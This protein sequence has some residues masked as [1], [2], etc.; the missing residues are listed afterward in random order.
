MRVR[1]RQR[2]LELPETFQWVHETTP[3]L[4]ARDDPAGDLGAAVDP[5]RSRPAADAAGVGCWALTIACSRWRSRSSR[6][7]SAR[8]VRRPAPAGY[9]SATPRTSRRRPWRSCASGCG[10]A[11]TRHGDR[12]GRRRRRWRSGRC[13]RSAT[14]RRSSPSPRFPRRAAAG[15]RAAITSALIAHA[16]SRGVETVFLSAADD[17]VARVYERLGFRRAAHGLLRAVRERPALAGVLGAIVIVVLGDPRRPRRRRAGHRRAVAQ[18][19]RAADRSACSRG[20]SAAAARRRERR[21]AAIAG[22]IFAVDL[23]L[24]H[25][26]IDD[27]GA[28]LATVLGNLQVVDRA[29]RRARCCSASRSRGRSCSRCRRSCLGVLLVSGALEDG[30]YGANPARG[31]LFGDRQRLRLR[32]VHPGPAPRADG[33]R[34]PGRALFDMSVVASVVALIAGPRARRRRPRCRPGR[35]RAG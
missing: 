24:W 13:A 15:S 31:A 8:R 30:A 6:S 29:V 9:A 2:E 33:P 23:T 28:G 11:S 10:P 26:A 1:A 25:D 18:R 4:R 14:P 16:L 20:A 5:R 19:L 27:V 7:G 3:T 32:D 12:R 21:L 35:A 17:D 22:V 34:P